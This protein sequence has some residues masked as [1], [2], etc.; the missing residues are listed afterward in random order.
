MKNLEKTLSS[1]ANAETIVLRLLISLVI[2]AAIFSLVFIGMQHFETTNAQTTLEAES[3]KII[4]ASTTL[5]EHGSARNLN[6]PNAKRGSTRSIELFLPSK[7]RYFSLGCLPNSNL[8]DTR[9]NFEG[10]L[11]SYQIQDK[12]PKNLWLTENINFKKGEIQDFLTLPQSSQQGVLMT[13]PGKYTLTL[14]L[15]EENNTFIILVY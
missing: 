5:L 3:N 11:L 4:S 9:Y 8:T 6:D 7:T 13:N 10:S 2:L 1:N 12:S 15:V 14:E